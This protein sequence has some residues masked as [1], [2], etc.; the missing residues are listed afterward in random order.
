MVGLD[1][2]NGRNFGNCRDFWLA[3]LRVEEKKK[4]LFVSRY[5]GA[6]LSIRKNNSL[7]DR[8]TVSH[9]SSKKKKNEGSINK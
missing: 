6:Y 3:T 2:R 5:R 8:S 7:E 9:H 4:R 1:G